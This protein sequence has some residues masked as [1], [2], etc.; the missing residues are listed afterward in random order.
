MRRRFRCIPNFTASY[1]GADTGEIREN[2]AMQ[3]NHPVRWQAILEKL[4]QTVFD[5]F[6]ETGAGKTLCGLVKKTVKGAKIIHVEDGA[7]L[8]AALAELKQEV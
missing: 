8:E 5:T 4:P 7:T 1:Y 2:I 3:I 6:V